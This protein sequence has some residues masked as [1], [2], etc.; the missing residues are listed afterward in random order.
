MTGPRKGTAA[1]RT[2]PWDAAEYLLKCLLQWQHYLDDMSAF[3]TFLDKTE[4]LAARMAR[5]R[6][7]VR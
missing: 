5:Q 3:F 7:V 6:G 2:R 4:V 1:A